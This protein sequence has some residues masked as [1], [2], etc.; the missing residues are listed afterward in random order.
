MN[1]NKK[2]N[3]S[4]ATVNVSEALVSLISCIEA[5]RN[6]WIEVMK[7][8]EQD[9]P[10]KKKNPALDNPHN[11]EMNYGSPRKHQEIANHQFFNDTEKDIV[12]N[13]TDAYGTEEA[14]KAYE[15]TGEIKEGLLLSSGK[16]CLVRQEDANWYREH[17]T[18]D[19]Y[20]Y[21]VW[22]V[23]P[24]PKDGIP[25]W[26]VDESIGDVF[27][28]CYNDDPF[29]KVTAIRN[30]AKFLEAYADKWEEKE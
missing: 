17:I 29:D 16:A 15:E 21:G 11:W 9:F 4:K 6:A 18:G 27:V 10:I 13:W 12:E 28:V 3:W 24:K 1:K 23:W 8:G 25:Y 26:V 14:V 19:N 5:G 2:L 20:K 22:A 30:T 7:N